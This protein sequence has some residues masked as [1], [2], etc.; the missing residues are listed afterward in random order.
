MARLKNKNA[1]KHGVYS[2]EGVL[3]WESQEDFDALVKELRQTYPPVGLLEEENI[4][5]IARLKL[6]KRRVGAAYDQAVA[7]NSIGKQAAAAIKEGPDA[8]TVLISK[9]A[10]LSGLSSV[11]VVRRIKEQLRQQGIPMPGAV[12]PPGSAPPEEQATFSTTITQVHEFLSRL[13]GLPEMDETLKR[14]AAIDAQIDKAMGRM[15]LLR[16][17]RRQY[18]A[19]QALEGPK[20]K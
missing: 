2:S 10:E 3:P 12:P 8:L 18:G 13:H 16:E 6:R 11:E 17:F 1:V 15:A 7:L 9:G 14:E 19:P 5:D 20:P 4:R